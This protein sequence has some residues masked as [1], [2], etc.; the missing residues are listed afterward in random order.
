MTLVASMYRHLSHWPP[1]LA[2]V[3]TMLAPL[4]ANGELQSLVGAARQA[5]RTHGGALA[6]LLAGSEPPVVGA[7]PAIAAIRRFVEH[8]IARMTGICA[9]S[10]QTTPNE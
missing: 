5:A 7:G 3:R 4:H 1:Y 6:R 8:P 10:R 2:L 9:L